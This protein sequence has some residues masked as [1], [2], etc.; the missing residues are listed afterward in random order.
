MFLSYEMNIPIAIDIQA[1]I[2][3]PSY[4]IAALKFLAIGLLLHVILDE[5]Q[6]GTYIDLS[7]EY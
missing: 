4:S 2:A 1:L 6:Y 3:C 5:C 7:L